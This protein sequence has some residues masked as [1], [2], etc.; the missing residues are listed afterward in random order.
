MEAVEFQTRVKN[1]MIQIPEKYK[2][3]FE[4]HVRVVLMQE[5]KAES[6][7][8]PKRTFGSARGEVWMSDDFDE[9]LKMFKDYGPPE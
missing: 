8:A 6:Q 9:P 7:A 4:N 1:G 5:G 2:T 3:Q